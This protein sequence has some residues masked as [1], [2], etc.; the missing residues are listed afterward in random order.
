MPGA[1][2]EPGLVC[3]LTVHGI[4]F[5]QP[6]HE[7][8]DSPGYADALHRHL[9]RALGTRLGDD[10]RRDRNEPGEKG[11]VYVSSEWPPRSGDVEMGLDRIA[12]R[13]AQGHLDWTDRPLAEPGSAVGHVAVV[14]A[15]LE[16]TRPRLL[17]GLRALLAALVHHGRYAS[18]LTVWKMIQADRRAIRPQAVDPGPGNRVRADVRHRRMLPHPRKN[19]VAPPGSTSGDTLVQLEDDVASYVFDHG[20]HDRILDFVG[21]V[22]QRLLARDDVAAVVVNGHSHGTVVCFDALQ[23]LSTQQLRRVGAFITAGSP[24]RKYVDL[25]G[26]TRDLAGVGEVP[27]LNFWDRLDPVADPLAPPI[28]WRPLTDPT[29]PPGQGGLFRLRR[30]GGFLDQA[31]VADRVVDN[32]T[33]SGVDGLVAH[34]YW[35]NQEQFIP[36]LAKVLTELSQ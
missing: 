8:P 17:V 13:D 23:P 28:E 31:H 36:A 10:P 9:R 3:L 22:L 1:A 25:F 26:H 27:W 29:V 7:E 16:S 19:R 33:H 2:Q 32:V 18:L 35:D 11:A 30:G 6:P 34:D 4:G 24:L 14:Y 15:G 5:Q 12:R 20:L 21:E